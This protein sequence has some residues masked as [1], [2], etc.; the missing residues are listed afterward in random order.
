[1]GLDNYWVNGTDEEGRHTTIGDDGPTFDPPLKLCGGI[2]SGNGDG[3]F[4]GKVYAQFIEDI[5]GVSLYGD[6]DTCI[7]SKD[8]CK[9]VRDALMD[10]DLTKY[11][12][13]YPEN[14]ESPDPRY[15]GWQTPTQ[16]EI[17]DLARMFNGFVGAGFYLVAWY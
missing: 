2:L 6:S 10:I 7:V 5:S 3:S 15:K 4:R 12:E 9:A 14:D 13:S 1:M 16:A 8:D 11:P 17:K